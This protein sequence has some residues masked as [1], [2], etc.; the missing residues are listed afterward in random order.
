MRW[1][2]NLKISVKLM[3]NFLIVILCTIAIGIFS[4]VQLDKV[5]ASSIVISSDILPSVRSLLELQSS[6]G[7]FRISELQ[8]ILSTKQE[9][10]E[11]AEKAMQSRKET[12]Q[13]QFSAY[14]ELVSSDEE[15][16]SYPQLVTILDNYFTQ[17]KSILALSVDNKKDEART[18]FKGDSNKLF[19]DF[20]N[21]IDKISGSNQEAADHASANALA[22]FKNSQLSIFIAI[23]IS[24][25]IALFLAIFVA[26]LISSPLKQAVTISR[27]VA[28][29]NL[30]QNITINSADETGQLM[31]SLDQ[32]NNGLIKI[33]SDVRQSAE[34]ISTAA[35]EIAAGNID[36]STRTEHQASSLEKTAAAL[37]ELTNTSKLTSDNM[38]Q[39]SQLADNA[40]SVATE[41]GVVVDKVVNIMSSINDSSRKIF[42]II[43]VIDSIAV[44]TNLL[45]L[46]AA[47]E[48]AR[49]GEQGR[50]FAV[51]AGEVRNLAQRSA[52]AA[53]EIKAL[54]DQSVANV[55]T[56]SQLVQQAGS[57]MTNIVTCVQQ[58]TSIVSEVK[59]SIKEQSM[60]ID[61][62]NTAIAQMDEGLQ[63]NAALVEESAAASV[64]LKEQ[65]EKLT[66]SVGTFRISAGTA[67]NTTLLA[68]IETKKIS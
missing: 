3:I 53:K 43:G 52:G 45:A 65:T 19:R 36:L 2:H 39:A 26:R 51:V 38:Q 66:V 64:S 9:D 67:S 46:N 49:A 44:Q 32:M 7:R 63:Q 17:N 62:I 57:T 29:G 54:I 21:T 59:Q 61:E 1:F 5:R 56:G 24:S 25:T 28:E 8:H 42:D 40:S 11:A 20:N 58:V 12:I 47:V 16:E 30:S 27:S 34:I 10:F 4:T 68:P 60:G 13:K 6:L 14:H 22:I 37:S 33:V 50:G 15:K 35:S 31:Q 55:D 18:L 48:A 23:F 41:G